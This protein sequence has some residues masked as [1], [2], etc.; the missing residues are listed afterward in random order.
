MKLLDLKRFEQADLKYVF[1]ILNR[2]GSFKSWNQ[3]KQEFG[4]IDALYFKYTQLKDSIPQTWLD[5][6]R[7][8]A[9]QNVPSFPGILQCTRLIP[10]ENLSS[11]QIYVILIR[12]KNSAPTAKAYFEALYPNL[13]SRDWIRIYLLP[14]IC[15]KDSYAKIFQY[16]IL[17]NTLYLNKKLYQF[18]L[19]DT[20][21]CSFCGVHEEDT[22]HLF[23]SCT[24]TTTL[25]QSLRDTLNI[26]IPNLTPSFSLLGFYHDNT[27]NAT[28]VNHI[29]LIFKIYVYKS[30][31]RGTLSVQ[32]LITYIKDIAIL[33]MNISTFTP[34][35]GNKYL[36]KWQP[37][38]ENI[39]TEPEVEL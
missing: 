4:L 31:E 19:S 25:W 22:I 28:L 6:I 36:L 2:D 37:I 5:L 10:L 15:A 17:N 1:Q 39:F 27:Q 26:P 9:V 38:N 23:T 16:K 8:Q 14:R 30:R 7:G 29:L 3:A 12:K 13:T 24:F 35:V 20:S 18:G 11:K 32:N 34:Q 33:E 21:L